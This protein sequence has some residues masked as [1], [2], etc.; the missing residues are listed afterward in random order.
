MVIANGI[1]QVLYMWT[2]LEK[3]LQVG[4]QYHDFVQRLSARAPWNKS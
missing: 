4:I 1:Q 2:Q 3:E